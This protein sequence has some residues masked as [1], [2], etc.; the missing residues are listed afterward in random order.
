[1]GMQKVTHKNGKD[2]NI[3]YV[4][5]LEFAEYKFT[6]N[7]N[8]IIF[9]KGIDMQSSVVEKVHKYVNDLSHKNI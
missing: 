9:N 1:M 8:V 7:T 4:D 2:R 6:K 3:I 5:G